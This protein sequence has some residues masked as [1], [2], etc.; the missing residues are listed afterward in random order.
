MIDFKTKFIAVSIY[1][2]TAANFTGL[3]EASA[4]TM[5]RDL[6]AIEGFCEGVVMADE[7]KS[8]VLIVTQWLSK[9]AWAQAHWEPRIGEAVAT[10]AENATSYDVQTFEPVTIV[11]TA[12]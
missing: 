5:Q 2:V 10:F 8:R 7:V 12:A 9:E 11:R 3:T 1:T 6:P 4:Q